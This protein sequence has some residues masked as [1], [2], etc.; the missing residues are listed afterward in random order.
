MS[1]QTGN[2]PFEGIWTALW[3]P[4]DESGTLKKETLNSHLDFL[5]ARG[6]NGIVLCGST[7]QFPYLNVATRKELVHFVVEKIGPSRVFVNISD[8]CQANVKE[9]A[10]HANEKKVAAVM[11]LPQ[12]YYPYEPLDL[13]TY[14]VT[15]A[16]IAGRPLILYNFPECA[17]NRID[18]ETID[19]VSGEVPLLGIKQS[20][21]DFAYQ[22]Q[23]IDLGRKYGFNVYSGFDTRLQEALT[24]GVTGS[25]G[26]M[27]N[28][29]PEL[30]VQ[31]YQSFKKND[32]A[33]LKD[34]SDKVA[35]I[36]RLLSRVPFPLSIAALMEAKNLDHGAHKEILSPTTLYEYGELIRAFRETLAQIS[37]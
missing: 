21:S 14:F 4:T 25:I 5:L 30:M 26:G 27:S 24:L 32:I 3:T 19:N 9:L 11:L 6:V 16:K 28:A 22:R 29:I 7:G 2:G 34:A 1:S 8:I 18:L 13:T 35:T 10:L 12:I 31:I 23:L 20:G 15:M 33:A 36:G 37:T 17:R